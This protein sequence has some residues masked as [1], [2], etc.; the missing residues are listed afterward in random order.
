[1]KLGLPAKLAT[2]LLMASPFSAH[3]QSECDPLSGNTSFMSVSGTNGCPQRTFKLIGSTQCEVVLH[4][5]Q[6]TGVEGE[7]FATYRYTGLEYTST[8]DPIYTELNVI[9]RPNHEEIGWRPQGNE[10][11]MLVE[12]SDKVQDSFAALTSGQIALS[13]N[14]N[15]INTNVKTLSD[16]ISDLS[17]YVEASKTS[18]DLSKSAADSAK[19]SADAAKAASQSALLQTQT[20]ADTLHRI[21][22]S[23]LTLPEIDASLNAVQQNIQSID[24]KVI[25][26]DLKVDEIL[27]NQNAPDGIKWAIGDLKNQIIQVQNLLPNPWFDPK[28]QELLDAIQA[29]GSDPYND[30]LRHQQ[31]LSAIDNIDSGTGTGGGMTEQQFQDLIERMD[32]VSTQLGSI[33]QNAVYIDEN[34]GTV[35]DTTL[36]TQQNTEATNSLLADTNT[37]LDDLLTA[38]QSGSGSDDDTATNEKLDAIKGS[39]DALSDTSGFADDL[40]QGTAQ[41]KSDLNQLLDGYDADKMLTDRFKAITDE[42][43]NTLKSSGLSKFSDPSKF[44]NDSGMVKPETFDDLVSF[45]QRQS[46]SPYQM[47]IR[48]NSYQ[49]DLCPY[50]ADSSSILTYVFAVLTAIFC[51]VMI[52]QTLINERLS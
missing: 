47:T 48:G 36:A 10:T 33:D 13:K 22:N 28:H 44:I 26:T 18:S 3:S 35:Y 6:C 23:M 9:P 38:F 37:K 27:E 29:N 11:L 4:E 30:N 52:S 41:G 19:L 16:R 12:L 24:D 42:A 51:F 34:L 39:L 40:A 2:F 15:V 49:M 32:T 21:E 45:A 8:Y 14:D 7:W 17:T 5:P 43:E 46:C 50:A 31:L 25:E 20:N 1:M